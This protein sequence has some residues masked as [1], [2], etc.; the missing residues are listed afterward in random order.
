M[1]TTYSWPVFIVSLDSL[2]GDAVAMLALWASVSAATDGSPA[3]DAVLMQ[4]PVANVLIVNLGKAG[5]YTVCLGTVAAI[6]EDAEQ[7]LL[8]VVEAALCGED[9]PLEEEFDDDRA[10]EI[11]EHIIDGPP[12][13]SIVVFMVNLGNGGCCGVSV[14]LV[15]TGECRILCKLCADC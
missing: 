13:L 1:M 7:L 2:V 9:A 5:W 4:L 11:E 14:R 6:A 8:L 12:V 3:M 15:D 10:G